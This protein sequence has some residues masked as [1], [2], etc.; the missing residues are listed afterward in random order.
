MWGAGSIGA[1]HA[2]VLRDRLGL[3]PVVVPARAERLP[4]V[5]A[6]G[7][8]TRE[9]LQQAISGQNHSAVIVCTETGRHLADTMSA[10]ALGGDVLCEKPLAANT[11]GLDRLEAAARSSGRQVFVACNLRFDA[12]LRG[13]RERL[14]EIGRVHSVRVECQSYLP[15]W[16]PGSDYRRGYSARAGQGGVLRDLIHEIDYATWIF[17]HPARVA[18]RMGNTG[19]LGIES[20]EWAELWWTAPSGANLSIYLDYLTR[21]PRRRMRAFGECGDIEWDAIAQRVSV[22]L[23]GKMEEAIVTTQERDERMAEQARAFLE[24]VAGGEAGL[25]ATLE[26]GASAVALCDAAR[27]SARSGHAESVPDWR[28]A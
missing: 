18:A 9:E 23:A 1:R 2:N 11:Q 3:A 19:R 7:F 12:G 25:L 5:Q 24:A 15:D 6:R 4:E 16:R 13:F 20:E 17:G 28:R 27:R 21:I 8:E 22:R 26:E 10:L 14:P